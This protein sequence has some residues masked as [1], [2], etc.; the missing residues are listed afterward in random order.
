MASLLSSRLKHGDTI[1]VSGSE[2]AVSRV[3]LRA[4]ANHCHYVRA[5]GE[6]HGL[7]K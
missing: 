1:S 2:L 3:S 5:A 4:A 6:V 7:P